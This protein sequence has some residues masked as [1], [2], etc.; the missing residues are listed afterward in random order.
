M[1]KMSIRFRVWDGNLMWYPEEEHTLEPMYLV[2]P[3]GSVMLSTGVLRDKNGE[4]VWNGD[5][6]EGVHGT[7]GKHVYFKV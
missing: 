1:L 6:L 7:T 4:E 2:G 3:R 5:I